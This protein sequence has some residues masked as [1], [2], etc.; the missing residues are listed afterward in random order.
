MSI[1]HILYGPKPT[2]YYIIETKIKMTN[3]IKFHKLDNKKQL[4]IR[5]NPTF[6]FLGLKDR[7]TWTWKCNDR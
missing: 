2:K 1:N 6:T 3:C 4:N 5:L 7:S